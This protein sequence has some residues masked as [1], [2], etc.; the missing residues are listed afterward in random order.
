MIEPHVQLTY[1]DPE[2]D[3]RLPLTCPLCGGDV[4]HRG[5]PLVHR[6][7]LSLNFRCQDCGETV[8]L[9]ISPHNGRTLIYWR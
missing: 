5:D 2:N 4:L 7:G 8:E 6:Y 1:W 9:A 3:H